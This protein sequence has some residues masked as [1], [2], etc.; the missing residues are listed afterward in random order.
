MNIDI[1]K[2]ALHLMVSISVLYLTMKFFNRKRKPKTKVRWGYT[3]LDSLRDALVTRET[4][5]GT[6][7]DPT[8]FQVETR[9]PNTTPFEYFYYMMDGLKWPK[10][11]Y[12][13][14]SLNAINFRVYP[15]DNDWV[16]IWLFTNESG[17]AFNQNLYNLLKEYEESGCHPLSAVEPVE[18]I[19]RRARGVELG[20]LEKYG[21]KWNRL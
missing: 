3:D 6:I 12:L 7:A 14:Y 2:I 20:E 15:K 17:H 4:K 21:Y 10:I 1:L 19:V 8:G 16:R 18:N 11:E 5:R 9:H 13:S